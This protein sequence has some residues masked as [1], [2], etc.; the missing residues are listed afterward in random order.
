MAAKNMGAETNVWCVENKV[1]KVSRGSLILYAGRGKSSVLA[2]VGNEG[3]GVGGS[4]LGSPI[5]VSGDI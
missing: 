5:L 4:G 2:E 1:F 3:V